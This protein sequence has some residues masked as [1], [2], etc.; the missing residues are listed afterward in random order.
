LAQDQY[1]SPKKVVFSAY[2]TSFVTG[3]SPVTLDVQAVLVRNSIDGFID[4]SGGGAL[5]YEYSEDGGS[6]YNDPVYL[7]G[8]TI[9]SL[10][11]LSISHLRIT[12]VADTIYQV[13]LT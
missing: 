6:T 4:N 1:D 10:R 3:D 11:T 12:W 5:L 9:D 7:P 8:G 2:D 13:R